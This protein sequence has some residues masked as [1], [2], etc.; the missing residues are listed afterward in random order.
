MPSSENVSGKKL[1]NIFTSK[2]A[3]MLLLSDNFHGSLRGLEHFSIE[4]AK[5]SICP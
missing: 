5:V 3:K 1:S 4:Y 2:A